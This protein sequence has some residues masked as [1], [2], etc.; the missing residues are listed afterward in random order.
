MILGKLGKNVTEDF[1]IK[2]LETNHKIGTKSKNI[3]LFFKKK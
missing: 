2:Q 1:L 3:I